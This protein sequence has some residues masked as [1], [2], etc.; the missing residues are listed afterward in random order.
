[1]RESEKEEKLKEY[2]IRHHFWRDKV[3]NQMAY[4][5]NLFLTIGFGLMGFMISQKDQYSD[6]TISSTNDCNWNVIFFFITMLITFL[7]IIIGTISVTS[8]LFDL[9]FTSNILKTR[10]K[11]LKNFDKL[12]SDD[13]PDETNEKNLI[14]YFKVMFGKNYRISDKDYLN[15]ELLEQKFMT[16]RG[17][18][19]QLGRL[20]WITH[21]VQIVV[22]LIAVLIYGFLIVN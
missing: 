15:L 6:W 19:R 10:K 3:F 21:K 8:R 2:D 16:L 22:T 14:S 9:R 11:T 5:I 12:L 7:S 18:T 13:F 17:L 20:S 4:S 1:M